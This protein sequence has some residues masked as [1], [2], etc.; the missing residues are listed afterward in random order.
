MVARLLSQV[1]R[2]SEK[3][4]KKRNTP[5]KKRNDHLT[6]NIYK[7]KLPKFNQEFM[8]FHNFKPHVNRYM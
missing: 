8:N 1:F 2:S 6:Y 7:C 5:E 4:N 3:K